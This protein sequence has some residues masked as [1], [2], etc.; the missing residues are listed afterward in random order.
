[1][2]ETSSCNVVSELTRKGF[3]TSRVLQPED[4]TRT[5]TRR[6]TRVTCQECAEK[7]LIEIYKYTK[8]QERQTFASS[9]KKDVFN[10]NNNKKNVSHRTEHKYLDCVPCSLGTSTLRVTESS[11]NRNYSFSSYNTTYS[12]IRKVT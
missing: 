1:M 5:R 9:S 7:N 12:Y 4:E 2:R 3:D 6:K 8:L 10:K 11:K